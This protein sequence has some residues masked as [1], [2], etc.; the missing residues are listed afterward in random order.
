MD[1]I[2]TTKPPSREVL[3]LRTRGLALAGWYYKETNYLILIIFYMKSL[4]PL[5]VYLSVLFLGFTQVTFAQ[6]AGV[7]ISPSIIEE[8]LDAGDLVTYELEIQNRNNNEQEFFLFTRNIRSV[9]AGG[10]P[11][12]AED[13]EVTG[14]ELASWITLPVGSVRLPAN[15]SQKIQFT[16]QVPD[17]ASPGSHF[18]GIFV[19]ADPPEL[20]NS[21][22]AV[23]YQVANIISI[24]VSGDVIEEASIRQFSTGKFLYGA[25]DVDFQL[26]IENEGSVLVRPSGP[27]EIYN[28][29]GKKVGSLTFNDARAGVFPGDTRTY[30]DIQWVG[31]AVGFGRYEAIISPAYGQDGARKT[32]SSTVTFWI[33]PFDIIGPAFGVLAV[34]LLVT[35]IA[36]RLYIKRALSQMNAGRRMVRRR[37]NSSATLLLLVAVLIVLAL[38][39]LV[40]LVLFA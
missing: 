10:E 30:T 22:A 28:S 2:A 40:M 5:F 32:M 31:D 21:G 37:N 16:M 33:L 19:S 24:R 26:R 34:L 13:W 12:F 11:V 1:Y 25:Q 14:F 4:R 9:G 7:A 38:F 35:V 8:T 23:G 20:E 36:V 6:D 15:E 17:D 39:L 29:L 3:L 18:G 27:L